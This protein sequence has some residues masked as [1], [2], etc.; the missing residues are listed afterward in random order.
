MVIEL[1]EEFTNELEETSPLDER[2]KDEL[3][4]STIAELDDSSTIELEDCSTTELE[5]SPA[6][7]SITTIGL[8]SPEQ[9]I[10]ASAVKAAKPQKKFFFIPS[11]LLC[12]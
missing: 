2:T 5:E 1:E 8:L 12:T 10:S 3:E 4:D 6:T 11:P 7:G 9:A